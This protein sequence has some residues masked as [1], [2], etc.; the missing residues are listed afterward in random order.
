MS[1]T[2]STPESVWGQSPEAEWTRRS[3][4]IHAKRSLKEPLLAD[5]DLADPQ[6][7]CAVRFATTQPAQ[8]LNLL[9][10]EF[11]N[12]QAEILAK[13]V[14]SENAANLQ[15]K[16]WLVLNKVTARTPDND[17]VDQG[18]AFIEEMKAKH[19]ATDQRAFELFCLLALNL[20]EFMYID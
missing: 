12:K 19:G 1:R 8:A 9:N 7:N 14:E 5:F 16:V 11:V 4:Y 10:S 2:S 18:L 13:R 15:T 17:E 20:N 6:T 3:I